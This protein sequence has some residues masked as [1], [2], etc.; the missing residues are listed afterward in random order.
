MGKSGHKEAKVKIKGGFISGGWLRRDKRTQGR[1]VDY[2]IRV[3]P[4]GPEPVGS[5]T[6][7]LGPPSP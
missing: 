4:A 5:K 7:I 2:G 6:G 1:R 3:A